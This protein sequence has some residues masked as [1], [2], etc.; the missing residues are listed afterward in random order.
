MRQLCSDPLPAAPEGP[1]LRAD[2]GTTLLQVRVTPNAKRNAI[3]GCQEMADGSVSLRVRVTAQPEKGKANKAVIQL[4]AKALG[5][6]K[7]DFTL[8][9]GETARLKTLRIHRAADEVAPLI[10]E[11]LRAPKI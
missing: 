3:E 11:L 9:S 7:S 1:L 5:L 6:A 10:D 8:E 2:A 4:L